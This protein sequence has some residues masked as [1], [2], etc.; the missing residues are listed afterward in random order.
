MPLAETVL[1]L[2]AVCMICYGEAAFTKRIS[3]ETEV[4][5]VAVDYCLLVVTVH[6]VNA[7]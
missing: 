1:K 3:T 2:Q 5:D 7:V 4:R 6:I